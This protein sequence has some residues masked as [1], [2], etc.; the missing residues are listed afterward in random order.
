[1]AR[2]IRQIWRFG[3]DLKPDIARKDVEA[4][5]KRPD[6]VAVHRAVVDTARRS[7]VDSAVVAALG[8]VS[9]TGQRVAL[10]A[11]DDTVAAVLE[12]VVRTAATEPSV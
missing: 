6:V 4:T 8:R 5:D 12:L 9:P 1:M 2:A 3:R 11:R 10:V 7:G